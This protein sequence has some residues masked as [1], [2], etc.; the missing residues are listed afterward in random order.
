MW[1]IPKRSFSSSRINRTE[2]IEPPRP[3]YFTKATIYPF[4]LLSIMTSLALNLSYSKTA[5]QQKFNS[6]KAQIS[7]LQS[8]LLTLKSTTKA[9]ERKK[10]LSTIQRE[11]EMVGLGNS[12]DHFLTTAETTWLEVL[13]GKKQPEFQPAEEEEDWQKGNPSKN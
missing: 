11:L 13:F 3:K 2:A 5:N 12:K 9:E 7:V 6:L 4:L 1:R 10:V 8:S